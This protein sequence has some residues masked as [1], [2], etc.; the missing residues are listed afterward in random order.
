[1]TKTAANLKLLMENKSKEAK[2][3]ETFQGTFVEDMKIVPD[4]EVHRILNVDFSYEPSSVHP[5]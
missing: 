3:R 4:K 1:M 2:S 5:S